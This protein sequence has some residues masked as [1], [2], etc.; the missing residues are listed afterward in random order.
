MSLFETI[1]VREGMEF[2]ANLLALGAAIEPKPTGRGS[3][4]T[5]AAQQMNQMAAQYVR[6]VK[7]EKGGDSV[8]E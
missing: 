3:L 7:S 8:R 4:Y 2:Q 5:P 1:G 6:S